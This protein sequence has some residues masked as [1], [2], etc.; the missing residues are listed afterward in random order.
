MGAL[1]CFLKMRIFLR[2]CW[3]VCGSKLAADFALPKGFPSGMVEMP[4]LTVNNKW[5][6]SVQPPERS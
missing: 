5:L 3:E 2:G 4:F 6:K 1:H